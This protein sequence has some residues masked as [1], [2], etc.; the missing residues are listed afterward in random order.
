MT[1]MPRFSRKGRMS[2]SSVSIDLLLTSV[3]R[4]VRAQDVEDDLVVLGGVPRPVHV[5]AVADRVALE[6]LEVVGEVGQ[7][8]LLDRR[9]ERA[10]L[11][12]LRQV[13]RFRGRASCAGPTGAC[14]ESRRGP[15]PR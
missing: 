4:A 3:R 6:L 7:R 5:R 9:G 11:L 10:Q 15:S 13:A 12:P 2:H 1:S 8:V 14:R